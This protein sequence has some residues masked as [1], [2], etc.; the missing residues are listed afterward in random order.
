MP[1]STYDRPTKVLMHDFA[2]EKL[3]KGQVFHKG[4]AREWFAEHYPNL[5]PH[6]VGMHVEGMA[7]NN[8]KRRRNHPHIKPGSQHD[9]FWK[10]GPGQFRL[11]DPETDPPPQYG[12][13]MLADTGTEAPGIAQAAVDEADDEGAAEEA[14]DEM[15]RALVATSREF[16][17]ERDLKNY[18]A[19]NLEAIEPGLRLYED[20]GFTGIEFPV[21]GRFIDIL[22]IGRDDAFVVVE[23]KVSRGY[24][25]TMG[26]LM[27]YMGW[28]RKNLAKG[29]PVRGV[30][31]ASGITEDLKLAAWAPDVKL[32]EYE[33]EFR[34]KAVA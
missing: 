7:V 33:I 18:L 10:I 30:I 25:R 12:R 17:F 4:L 15:E 3:Q 2:A 24:D 6:T 27:R 32:V 5:N 8:A 28:I 26:Q 16:A 22:A 19:R 1:A 20:E 14:E 11:W 21:G 9:L 34:L 31:V 13:E 23:L 29:K